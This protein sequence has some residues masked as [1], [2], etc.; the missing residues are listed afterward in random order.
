[1]KIKLFNKEV[2]AAAAAQGAKRNYNRQVP[3]EV[4]AGLPDDMVFPVTLSMLHEHAGGERVEP[5]I[6]AIVAVDPD[7][8]TLI[9]DVS[10]AVF[11]AL[12]EVEVKDGEIVHDVP[13]HH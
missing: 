11:L 9:L 10:M 5:H 4:I 8:E 13:Q 2:L 3:S 12:P 1:M 6:R 7:G